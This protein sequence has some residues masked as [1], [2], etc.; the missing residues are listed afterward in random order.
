M[1]EHTPAPTPSRAVYGFALYLNFKTYFIL[2]LLWAL[3]PESWF[4]SVGITYLPQ[5]YWAVAV[6]IFI[7]TAFALFVFVIYPS[8]NLC[9]TPDIDDARTIQDDEDD[10]VKSGAGGKCALADSACGDSECSC[11]NKSLCYKKQYELDDAAADDSVPAVE[12]L[13]I[14]D[15]SRIL[16]SKH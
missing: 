3:I 5:R 13:D 16:Y 11:S 14:R 15:V 12:D 8:I 10:V 9:M 2:Y 1:A 4:H 6:P 7:F